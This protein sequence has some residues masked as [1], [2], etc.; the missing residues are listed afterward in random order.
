M[1]RLN[2][3]RATK[4]CRD[5]FSWFFVV[6]FRHITHELKGCGLTVYAPAWRVCK[7][8]SFQNLDSLPQTIILR[9][10]LAKSGAIWVG[11]LLLGWAA[12]CLA[13]IRLFLPYLLL[14]DQVS[15]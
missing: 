1:T 10:A 5:G 6:C 8:S 7:T 12:P 13:G 9:A 14:K 15:I 4:F 3:N 11:R 2:L